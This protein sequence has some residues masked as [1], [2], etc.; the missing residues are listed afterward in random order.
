LYSSRK[1]ETP[2]KLKKRGGTQ[3]LESKW[4]KK[5]ANNEMKL[6]FPIILGEGRGKSFSKTLR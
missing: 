3:K 5:V 2:L 1:Q 6:D 4:S